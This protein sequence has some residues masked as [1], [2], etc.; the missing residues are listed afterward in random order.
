MTD[1]NEI[2]NLPKLYGGK[3]NPIF[4]T[5]DFYTYSENVT[6]KDLLNYANLSM[7]NIF[8]SLNQFAAITVQSIN[9]ISSSTLS[10]LANV[11]S[12]IQ[13]QFNNI[14]NNILYGY[15]YDASNNI[16]SIT[17]NTYLKSLSTN[18]NVAIAGKT[19]IADTLN[20]SKINNI[21]IKS[22][23]IKTKQLN[24]E[25]LL[26]NNCQIN[27]LGVY[28]YCNVVIQSFGQ[29]TVSI[30]PIPIF[31]STLVSNLGLQPNSNF[32]G[33]LI[34]KPKYR[35]DINSVEGNVLYSFTNNTD[36]IIYFV[37]V[38]ALGG[39]YKINIFYNSILI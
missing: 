28:L 2:K 8:T 18:N 14:I 37:P 9:E 20:T 11:T 35:I 12:D 36:E 15:S 27:D 16:T 25:M 24:T 17:N 6:F 19:S 13:G 38:N 21:E 7:V 10:Y 5:N 31:K 30:L 32:S 33:N 39:I 4:N 29:N 26:I 1:L 23:N 22:Q 34:I 3:L